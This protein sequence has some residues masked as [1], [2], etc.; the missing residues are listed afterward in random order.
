MFTIA[1]VLKSFKVLKS[2]N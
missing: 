2:F 1:A